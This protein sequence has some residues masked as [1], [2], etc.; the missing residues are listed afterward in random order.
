MV[1]VCDNFAPTN[2][3]SVSV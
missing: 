2:L 3:F 1:S